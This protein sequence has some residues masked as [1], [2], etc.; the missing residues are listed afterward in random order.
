MWFTQ[1]VSKYNSYGQVSIQIDS[2]DI[3]IIFWSIGHYI[4]QVFLYRKVY[5][6]QESKQKP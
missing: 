5:E 4:R 3:K 6:G 2:D 1:I